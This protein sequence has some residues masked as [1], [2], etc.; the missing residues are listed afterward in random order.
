[1]WQATSPHSQ[2]VY[3]RVNGS[4]T[5]QA[6]VVR[7]AERPGPMTREVPMRCRSLICGVALATAL[8]APAGAGEVVDF[9]K[10]PDFKGQWSRP[11]DGSPNNWIRLGGQPPL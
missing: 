7:T 1:M 4:L 10:Y 6:P 11:F 5:K 8:L 2:K 9:S 3:R